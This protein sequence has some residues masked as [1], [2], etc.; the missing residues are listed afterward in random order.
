M[1]FPPALLFCSYANLQGYKVDSAGTGA[2]WSGI[3][4]LLAGRRRPP[5]MRKFGA[6]GIIRGA[7]MGLC[8]VN[9]V[10]GGLAYMLGDRESEDEDE[11]E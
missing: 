3:Y 9:L 5:L 8:F 1:L 11:E 4:L 10:G 7:T 2:A 6:R